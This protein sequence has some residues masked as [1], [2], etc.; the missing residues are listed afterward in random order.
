MCPES[1]SNWGFKNESITYPNIGVPNN[2][3][4][5]Q[6]AIF[7]SKEGGCHWINKND[8]IF[9]FILLPRKLTIYNGKMKNQHAL[10]KALKKTPSSCPSL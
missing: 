9:S 4:S 7:D 2:N 8:S 1:S 5:R 3:D 10:I 6:L